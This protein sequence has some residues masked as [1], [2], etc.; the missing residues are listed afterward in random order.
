MLT[1]LT[2]RSHEQLDI[3]ADRQSDA[4]RERSERLMATLDKFNLELVAGTVK[5]GDGREN[6]A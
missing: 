1:D 5:L 4:E 6:A 3:L 2:D